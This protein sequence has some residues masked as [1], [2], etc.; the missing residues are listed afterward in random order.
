MFQKKIF[1]AIF[2]LFIST[3]LFSHDRAQIIEDFER[4]SVTLQS[5]P[6][7]DFDPD[8]WCI[9]STITHNN[10]QYS[11][12]LFGNTWKVEQIDPIQLDTNSVWS[13]SATLFR[14]DQI[15][16]PGSTHRRYQDRR[17]PGT[18]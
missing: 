12:K 11:L 9:D 14:K 18:N 15:R 3:F 2:L 1:I 4:G 7:Q 6:G 8:D 13:V 16:T 10:S 5:Y 17:R